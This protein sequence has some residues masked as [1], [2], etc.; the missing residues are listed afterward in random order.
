M[1]PLQPA[2]VLVGD[3]HAEQLQHE[4]QRYATDYRVEFAR[5]LGPA[6]S[7]VQSL[8]AQHVEI[9]LFV[10]EFTQPDAPGLVTVDCL[11]AVSAV[12]KRALV[13]AGEE[14]RVNRETLREA[15]VDG[16]IEAG[17]GIPRGERDEE[18]HTAV[19]EL[20]SDWGWSASKPV[21]EAVQLISPPGNADAGRLRDF[22]DRLG[23]PTRNYPPESQVA[24]ELLADID[25]PDGHPVY[26]VL[27]SP[28]TETV[29]Q[30]T[31]ADI[32]RRFY[33][34]EDFE[35]D[36]VFDLA[37]IGAGPAGLAAAVYGASEGLSTVVF[38][39]DAI[40]G[41]AGTSSMIRNY[42]GFPRGISGMRLA[43]RARAQ[44]AR[45]GAKLYSARPVVGMELAHEPGATHE[46][47]LEDR[48]VHARS[49][50]VA[51]GV[52]YRRIG[53]EQIEKFVGLGVHYGAATSSARE[54]V[55]KDVVV[56]G[57][58]NSA[59]Q[60]AVHLSRFARSVKI[61]IRRPDLSETMSDYLIR[62]IE[63]NPRIGVKPCCEV[64][65][66]G[67]ATRLEWVTLRDN[68]TGA[69]LQKP[70]GGLF[71]LL[72]ADPCCDWLPPEI[73]QDSKGFVLTGR[74][75]PR[76]SWVDDCPPEPLGTTVPG[77]F[78]AG[79]IR[80]GSMKRVASASGE[81]AAAIPSVHSYLASLAPS[82]DA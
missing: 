3:A 43:Q 54:C 56:V 40:G 72:G 8:I 50:I 23:I 75:V 80:S 66:A 19:T 41:Q 13:Y 63:I 76:E 9:A 71:L 33:A 4:F 12:T 42:L 35:E 82:L 81:G 51:A 64:V 62:E 11:H 74:D 16:R 48:V 68:R 18:F 22:L 69:E 14:F 24:Q 32:G 58:G 70:C 65:D 67:G 55:G 7:L 25:W 52:A 57:G 5:G 34:F 47:R 77:I 21:F 26:P 49:L 15:Q 2:I 31:I 45:F 79:D 27:S 61:L 28:L 44:A 73:A 20:L 38:D 1:K 17:L 46:L 53:V 36:D 30:P 37:V 59:G 6:M 29:V 78:A 10:V 39:S 60:A